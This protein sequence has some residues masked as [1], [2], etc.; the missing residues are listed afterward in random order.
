MTLE[1]SPLNL[2][3]ERINIKNPASC[4]MNSCKGNPQLICLVPTSVVLTL[5]FRFECFIKWIY[6][7]KLI[8]PLKFKMSVFIELIILN[9][10]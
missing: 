4:K 1:C 6:P 8:H 3:V 10:Y 5:T 9:L 2:G 7:L